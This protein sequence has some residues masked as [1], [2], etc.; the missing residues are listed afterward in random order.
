MQTI[1]ICLIK[2]VETCL[3]ITENDV[4]DIEILTNGPYK[5]VRL[6]HKDYIDPEDIKAI[7]IYASMVLTGELKQCTQ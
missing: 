1:E 2:Y 3:K 6:K 4:K 7:L 5:A